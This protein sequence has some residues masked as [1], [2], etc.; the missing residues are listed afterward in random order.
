M[1]KEEEI[2]A[3]ILA[4]SMDNDQIE[5]LPG[6]DLEDAI[7]RTKKEKEEKGK[8]LNSKIKSSDIESASEIK[9]GAYEKA[10]TKEIVKHMNTT[11]SHSVNDGHDH[12]HD[13]H[14]H[15]IQS[16]ST[17]AINNGARS[18]KMGGLNIDAPKLSDEATGIMISIYSGEERLPMTHK[19]FK[20]FPNIRLFHSDTGMKMY[21]IERAY[22]TISEAEAYLKDT[23]IVDYPSASV[24]VFQN[25]KITN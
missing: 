22:D 11:T 2:E 5:L 23:I 14:D 24:V 7:A 12:G 1:K 10:D 18:V 25:G 4:G 6:E 9:D 20:V 3:E 13:G 8:I 15:H 19:A 16:D 17:K 21:I